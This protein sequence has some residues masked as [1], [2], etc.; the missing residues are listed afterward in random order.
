M[1]GGCR[2]FSIPI[3]PFFGM[4]DPEFESVDDLCRTLNAMANHLSPKIRQE[5][6]K[7]LAMYAERGNVF[8]PA[9]S[10]SITMGG[11]VTFC[12]LIPWKW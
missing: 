2:Y 8:E 6:W 4:F 1:T 11:K 12:G 5:T 10:E 7:R 9:I 3:T